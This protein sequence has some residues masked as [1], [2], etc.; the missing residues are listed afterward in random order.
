MAEGKIYAFV[1]ESGSDT[2][3]DRFFVGVVVLQCSSADDVS[4]M[5]QALLRVEQESGRGS[6]KWCRS[7]PAR[8]D[9]YLA[10][11]PPTLQELTFFWR[12]YYRGTEYRTW[13]LRTLVDAV[14]EFDPGRKVCAMVDALNPKDAQWMRSEASHIEVA[15]GI[16]PRNTW[17]VLGGRDGSDPLL[18]LADSLVGFTR[19][20]IEGRPYCSRHDV[21]LRGLRRLS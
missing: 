14:H 15:R 19:H 10:L 8:R 18:R 21:I 3:G 13:T 6:L 16:K 5:R 17:K 12:V 20:S 11:I 7:D 4:A 9:D 1:D 2:G